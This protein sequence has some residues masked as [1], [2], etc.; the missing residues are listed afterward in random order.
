[1]NRSKVVKSLLSTS[2]TLFVS[3]ASASASNTYPSMGCGLYELNGTLASNSM[4]QFVLKMQELSYAPLEVILLGGSFSERLKRRGTQVKAVVYVPRLIES[5][6]APFAYLQK[7]SSP[8]VTK[9][10]TPFRLLKSLDC[11]LKDYLTQEP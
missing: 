4:G 9:A 7:I 2:I 5:N 3:L 8:D 11:S 6:N 10:D 1:M